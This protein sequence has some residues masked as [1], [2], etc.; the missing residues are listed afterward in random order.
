M[1]PPAGYSFAGGLTKG[2]LARV[3]GDLPAIP[4]DRNATAGGVA[5]GY[6]QYITVLDRILIRQAINRGACHA[7]ILS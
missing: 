2:A 7:M 5:A 4:V 1:V 3:R 6:R